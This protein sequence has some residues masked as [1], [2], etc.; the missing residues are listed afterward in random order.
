MA[1][2]KLALQ[3]AVSLAPSNEGAIL[4][5]WAQ[6]LLSSKAAK[7]NNSHYTSTKIRTHV[8]RVAA[9]QDLLKDALSSI[10]A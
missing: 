9:T 4:A 2:D 5:T 8:S 1:S 7:L 10:F 6:F 3:K